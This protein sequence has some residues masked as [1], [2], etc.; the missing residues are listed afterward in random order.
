MFSKRLS[1]LQRAPALQEVA[2]GMLEDM[3]P[4]LWGAQAASLAPLQSH[5][6][7][8]GS[9]KKSPGEKDP[10]HSSAWWKHK[11]LNIN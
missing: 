10:G 3:G 9:F 11:R 1:E 7:L 2:G 8:D 4:S 6:Q 5:Q